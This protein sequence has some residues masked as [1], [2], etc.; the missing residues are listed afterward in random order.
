MDSHIQGRVW[1]TRNWKGDETHRFVESLDITSSASSHAE[2]R[3]A[4][5]TSAQSQGVNHLGRD[6][7]GDFRWT[8]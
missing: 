4:F 5:A 7:H 3:F 6:R 2:E 1:E 8:F